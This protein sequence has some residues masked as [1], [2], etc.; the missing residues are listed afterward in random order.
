MQFRSP[1]SGQLQPLRYTVDEINNNFKHFFFNKFIFSLHCFRISLMIHP[2]KI[3][4]TPAGAITASDTWKTEIFSHLSSVLRHFI[5]FFPTFLVSFFFF[6]FQQSLIVANP[7]LKIAVYFPNDDKKCSQI[8]LNYF[9]YSVY[10]FVSRS[11]ESPKKRRLIV[12]FSLEEN[13]KNF[14]SSC[15]PS[16]QENEKKKKKLALTIPLYSSQ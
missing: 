11:E 7:R 4:V 15:S 8:Q 2:T 9:C 5:I 10:R 12:E 16:H 6:F 14:T 1:I 3:V 13:V